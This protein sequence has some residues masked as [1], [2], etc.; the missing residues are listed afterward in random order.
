MLDNP[1]IPPSSELFDKKGVKF[2]GWSEIGTIDLFGTGP[3]ATPK[4]LKGV[5]AAAYASRAQRVT[6]GPLGAAAIPLGL[7]E[8]IPAFQTGMAQV[9][10]TPISYARTASAQLRGEVRDHA[11]RPVR[12]GRCSGDQPEPG[13]T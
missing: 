1:L 8:W 2:L 7:P 11:V 12:E 9:V 4:D 10:M 5:K 13:A 3:F 6:Y